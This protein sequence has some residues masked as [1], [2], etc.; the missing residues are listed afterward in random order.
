M[1]ARRF[2]AALAGTL[3]A[4][5]PAGA[6]TASLEGGRVVFRAAPG[7]ANDLT[8]ASLDG[9][10][11]FRLIDQGATL[12]AGSGC[13]AVSAN[14]VTCDGY[15]VISVHLR[16][17]DDVLSLDGLDP[18]LLPFSVFA[19][20]G[21]GADHLI[22][23]PAPDLLSGDGGDD[24]IEGR[25]G[26]A[27]IRFGSVGDEIRGGP[28]DDVLRGE[29][30]LDFLLG[31]PGADRMSGGP[32][33]DTVSYHRRTAPVRVVLDNRDNDG[34]RD[35]R[36]LIRPDVEQVVGGR[37]GD[38]LVGNSRPNRLQ[39]GR[40]DD[41]IRGRGG[42]DRLFGN[43]G[44]DDLGGGPGPDVVAGAGDPFS[45]PYHSGE[46]ASGS[47]RLRGGPGDDRLF[48]L[49]GLRDRLVDGGPGRD[50]AWVDR[51]IDPVRSIER[52]EFNHRRPAAHRPRP[53]P[54]PSL[55]VRRLALSRN[56]AG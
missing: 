37:A 8:I 55:S 47:D 6:G 5:A 23:G 7:E 43:N 42:R 30:G 56:P 25:G 53:T 34:R 1:T 46:P 18:Q 3:I 49:D 50:R 13:V 16:D 26:R 19:S 4:A 24:L 52:I 39:G 36:D 27:V 28:G 51:A 38:T 41:F 20:G 32:G 15:G 17:D 22:G 2:L 21:P 14:E 45:F 29:R 33:R 12:V 54:R 9:G 31:G 40:G 10:M 44:D 35:E 11:G 48:S